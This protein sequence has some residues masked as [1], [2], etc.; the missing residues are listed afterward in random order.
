MLRS[1]R[2]A[3][4]VATLSPE[5]QEALEV[6]IAQQRAA[7]RLQEKRKVRQVADNS[8]TATTRLAKVTLLDLPPET[9]TYIFLHLPFTSVVMCQGV[10][11][12]LQ[13]L[14][15]E[16]AELQYYIHLGIFGMVDNPHCDLPIS[17]RLNRL[18][19]KQRRWEEFDAEFYRVVDLPIVAE[20]G[21]RQLSGGVY[22][23]LY[24]S[25]ILYTMQVPRRADQEAEWKERTVPFL[26]TPGRFV[27]DQD[28]EIFITA[29]PQ[30]VYTSAAKPHTIHE[31]QV[32]LN[33]FSTGKPH[34]D[35]QRI[36]SFTTREEFENI[37][38]MVECVG[39]N[40][41]LILQNNVGIHE[42][43][44]QVYVYDWKTG[45]LKMRISASY[46]C[47]TLPVFLSSHMLLL[48]NSKTGQLE[49]WEIP[50]SL[51]ETTSNRPFFIL[52]LPPLSP[53]NGICQI[54]ARTGPHPAFGSHATPKPFYTDPRY[55]IVCFD[56]AIGPADMGYSTVTFV[57]FVHH[58]FLVGCLDT[59]SAFISS[60]ERP[61]P[62]PY[63]DWGPSACRWFNAR[64]DGYI[65]G[66]E[67]GTFGQKYVPRPHSP[68]PL[69][70][71]NFNPIDVA[72][73]LVSERHISKAKTRGEGDRGVDGNGGRRAIED[74]GQ[75][76]TGKEKE[77]SSQLHETSVLGI[78]SDVFT[79]GQE[80]DSSSSEPQL[81]TRIVTRGLDPLDDPDRY[82]ENT[83]YSS[84]PYTVRSLSQD[85]LDFGNLYMDE[86]CILNVQAGK[87]W[88][89]MA[90]LHL[91]HYG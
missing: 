33:Q 69:I 21:S 28:L 83:V 43:D 60:D 87:D 65:I 54:V 78:S 82:F 22:S 18:L 66:R 35:V 61:T 64:V 12:H 80:A 48:G 36:I 27:L 30:T 17:E 16:S 72:K 86:E 90:Q 50:Q 34:P 15:S 70:M 25:G 89:Y 13:A 73:A 29:Q 19:M 85:Q 42:P 2:M 91:F 40:L 20:S 10:N 76:H 81:T 37:W 77:V 45:E 38:V 39:D 24:N 56:V 26:I 1:Q 63:D 62:V 51:S 8:I 46:G 14:I 31:V 67:G 52:S 71:F 49:Y 6:Q 88:G 74:Q 5:Q 57:F 4:F 79:Q 41:A 47:Y 44:D 3:A 84:L 59:F 23:I 55:A 58:S 75:R 11:H 7:L 9:V 53:G 32:H 68:I